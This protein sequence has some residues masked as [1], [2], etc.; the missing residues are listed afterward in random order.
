MS[1][2]GFQKISGC[3]FVKKIQNKVSACFYEIAYLIVKILPVTHF[4][5]RGLAF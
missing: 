2:Y 3:S 1:A 4:R 5:E